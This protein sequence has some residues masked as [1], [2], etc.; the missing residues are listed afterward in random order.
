M[1]YA[2]GDRRRNLRA[3]VAQA[4]TLG[5]RADLRLAAEMAGT[6]AQLAAE[7]CAYF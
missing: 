6:Y 2:L 7:L 4:F 3:R 1:F 5:R